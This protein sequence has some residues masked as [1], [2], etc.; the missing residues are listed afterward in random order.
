MTIYLQTIW[1]TRLED[2][3][4]DERFV[5]RDTDTAASLTST[6]TELRKFIASI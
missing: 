2:D 5:F 1:R 6:P 3:D 4:E